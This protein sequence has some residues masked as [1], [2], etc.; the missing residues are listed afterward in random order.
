VGRRERAKKGGREE[1]R[2]GGREEGKVSPGIK[3]G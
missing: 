2:K 1:G 3:Q